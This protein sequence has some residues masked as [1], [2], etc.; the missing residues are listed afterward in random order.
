M[1]RRDDHDTDDLT[2]AAAGMR[3]RARTAPPSLDDTDD[4][5]EQPERRSRNIPVTHERR[6]PS[7]IDI[8]GRVA[9]LEVDIDLPSWAEFRAMRDEVEACRRDRLRRAKWR[10]AWTVLRSLTAASVVG[11][12]ALATRALV[13][14]GDA[15][16]SDRRES[17][18]V[19]KHEAALDRHHDALLLLLRHAVI[20]FDL[21]PRGPQ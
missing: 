17:A 7:R 5:I 4:E 1:T 6:R 19:E 12:L 13:D 14:Y 11:S 3:G 10:W 21:Y 2:A 15:R 16:N 8:E 9:Q 20:P 18:L